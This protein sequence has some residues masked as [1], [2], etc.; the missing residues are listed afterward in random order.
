MRL[1]LNGGQLDYLPEGIRMAT[2]VTLHKETENW[3]KMMFSCRQACKI[4]GIEY[5]EP[6][7]LNWMTGRKY[8]EELWGKINARRNRQKQQVY[9]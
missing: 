5:D 1:T 9:F 7:F 3:Q 2:K 8:F 6:E 4:L